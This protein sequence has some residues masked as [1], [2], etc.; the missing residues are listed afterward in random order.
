MVTS[1]IRQGSVLGLLLFIFVDDMGG[2]ILHT[3]CKSAS[4]T[5]LSGAV[6]TLEGRDATQRDP[7]SLERWVC[8]NL[9]MFNKAKRRVLHLGRGNPRCPY[10][11]GREWAESSPDEKDSGV[12]VDEKLNMAQQCVPA[13]QKANR[14]LGCIKR[15]VTSRSRE[16]ILSLYLALVRPHLQCCVQLWGPQHQKDMGL[17]ELAQRRP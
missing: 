12:L 15:S 3:L 2:R 4:D 8:A 11:L 6:D 9:L 14:T 16:G 13:A 5:K 1:G 10:R 17:L 7:G